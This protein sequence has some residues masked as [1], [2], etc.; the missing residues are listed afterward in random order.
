MYY[1]GK[2]QL[3][4][5]RVFFFC[6]A[7]LIFNSAGAND[8]EKTKDSKAMG[9]LVK[10][11]P[12]SNGSL[13]S[14]QNFIGT[15]HYSESSVVASQV[16]GLSLKVNFDTTEQVKKGQVLVELDHEILDSRINAIKASIKEIRLQIEKVNKDLRRY[17]KLIKQ[18]NISQQQYDEVY[19]N[20]TTL[21]QKYIALQAELDILNIERKQS[22]IRAPYS[23]FITQK[24]VNRGE[25]VDKGGAIATLVNPEK[26]YVLFDVPA[27]FASRLDD[28]Q[29]I[30]VTINEKVYKGSFEGVIIQGDSRTR[31]VPLKI[32]LDSIDDFFYGGL[33]AQIKLPRANQSDSILVPRDAVIKRF[34]QDV[35]FTIQDGKAQM[36]PVKVQIYDGSQVAVLAEGLTE[37]T[38]VITK[39]NE[40]IFP[41]QAVMEQ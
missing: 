26:V 8:K 18:K 31:T 14:Y 35:V 39:G 27:Q 5:L 29:E 20:K 41:G 12:V 7:I 34:G 36:I 1:F 2:L 38:K 3:L 15:L 28:A 37:Q 22:L 23:G 21:E 25:W 10:T 9:S 40:R 33:E 4:A 30:E 11:A 13:T 6:L 32:K 17:T 19:Y 24:R 16:A